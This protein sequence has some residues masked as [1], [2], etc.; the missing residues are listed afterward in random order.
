ML[1]LFIEELARVGL[2]VH[3]G[4]TM[5]ITSDFHNSIDYVNIS[6][7]IIEILDCDKSLNSLGKFINATLTRSTF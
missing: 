6:D 4:K 7:N 2:Q 5:I 3:D 1:A